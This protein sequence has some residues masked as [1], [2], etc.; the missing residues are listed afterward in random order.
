MHLVVLHGYLLSGSGSNIY[1]ANVAKAWKAM[2]HGVTVVCQDRNARSCEFV[3]KVFI[4]TDC[5]P[6]TAPD[7]GT[8]RVVVPDIDD[9][10]LVYVFNKYEGYT[11]KELGDENNCSF[12]EID[13]YIST[14]VSGL[15]RVLSQGVDRVLANHLFLGPVIAKRACEDFHVPY[16][17]KIHGSAITFSLKQRPQLLGYAI[18]GLSDCAKIVVGTAHVAGVMKS[19]LDD[20]PQKD[21]FERKMVTIPPG[22]DPN[23]FKLLESPSSNLQRFLKLIEEFAIR[24]P[25]GRN[26]LKLTLPENASQISDLRSELVTLCN[27]Y[28]QFSVDSDLLSRWPLIADDEPIIIYFGA[29]LHTKGVGELIACFPR[30]LEHSPKARL[31]LIGYGSYREN[32]EGMLLALKTGNLEDFVSYAQAGDFLDCPPVQL[33]TLF[34]QLSTEECERI[35]VTGIL[36]HK[37][38]SAILPLASIAVFPIKAPEA[39]GM[40]S[41]EAMSCGVFPICTYQTGIKGV[42]DVVKRSDPE[43]ESIMHIEPQAGGKHGCADGGKL[44]EQIPLA[45]LRAM[46]YLYP[47]GPL[48]WTKR[49]EVGRRLRAIAMEN[50]AW[51]KICS[52]LISIVLSDRRP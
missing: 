28:D 6:A 15:K 35:T 49:K 47:S 25:N 1:T 36:E 17:V 29:Y 31:L 8:V 20:C 2:G 43:L 23:T 11:V 9:L 3:D 37:Q 32:M 41:I 50:F 38:L 19:V 18:E 10:L 26:A 27:S 51:E 24:K 13:N 7:E 16:D 34:R 45:V 5:I 22:I 44:V 14:T 21:T 52:S 12:Q 46:H 33:G 48:D 39:F 42:L 4:G 40:V 30:I